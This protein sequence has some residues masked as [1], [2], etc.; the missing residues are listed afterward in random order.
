MLEKKDQS[1]SSSLT[2]ATDI[3]CIIR[4]NNT[5]KNFYYYENI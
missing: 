2:N 4:P 3:I 1:P 5:K